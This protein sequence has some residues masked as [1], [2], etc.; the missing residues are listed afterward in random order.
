MVQAMVPV[1]QFMPAALA[2]VLR[3]APLTPEKVAFAWRTAVGAAVDRASRVE[4][5]GTTLVVR[6]RNEQW[7]QE[8]ARSAALIRSRMAT[9][10]GEGAVTWI[11]VQAEGPDERA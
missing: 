2:S 3:L 11:D 7:R 1:H 6:V 8:L 4:L 5:H 10:L 9:V